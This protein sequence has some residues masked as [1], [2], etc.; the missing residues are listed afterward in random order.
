MNNQSL[1]ITVF[2]RGKAEDFLNEMRVFG[3]K[4]GIVVLGEGTARSRLLKILGLDKTQKEIIFLPPIEDK[5]ENAIH[6][7]MLENF[8][9]DKKRTGFIFSIPLS[10]LQ[11]ESILAE[12]EIFDPD[13]FE[14]QCLFVVVDEG[15]GKEAMRF[16][17]ELGQSGGTIIHG[18]GAGVPSDAYF[19]FNVEPQK[20]LLMILARTEKTAELQ[21]H[22]F[23]AMEL[24][25]PGKGIIFTLPVSR[26]TGSFQ[27]QGK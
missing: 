8:R 10:K 16:A 20:D 13:C 23:K 25:L 19:P 2:N 1:F 12:N 17:Q 5:Y 22:L 27:E 15:M 7:M 3:L 14:Y 11:R 18:R 21:K 9:V 6:E 4:G 24:D 26:V